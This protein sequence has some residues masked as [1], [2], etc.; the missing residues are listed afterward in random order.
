MARSTVR[1]AD[2]V[3]DRLKAL[4]AAPGET[5]SVTQLVDAVLRRHVGLLGEAPP[6]PV[7]TPVDHVDATP[8]LPRARAS[9]GRPRARGA[10]ARPDSQAEAKCTHPIGR[11]IGKQCAACGA[12]VGG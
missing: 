3:N 6:E 9:V 1:V 7:A 8:S 12:T 11:R 4:A 2:D 10:R 5:R